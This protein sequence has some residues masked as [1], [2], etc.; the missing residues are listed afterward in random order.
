LSSGGA[1]T[2]FVVHSWCCSALRP[3]DC[4]GM[5]SEFGVC[6][7]LQHRNRPFSH[8]PRNGSHLS[9]YSLFSPFEFIAIYA[10]HALTCAM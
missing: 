5:L 7:T 10:C 1:S 9:R 2:L 4:G 8:R 6:V 3:A